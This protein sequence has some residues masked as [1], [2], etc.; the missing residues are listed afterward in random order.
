MGEAETQIAHISTPQM[1]CAS[2]ASTPAG[3]S[4]M[5]N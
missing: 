5:M 2:F 1:G 3:Y 4:L